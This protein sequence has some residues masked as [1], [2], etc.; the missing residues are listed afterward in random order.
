MVKEIQPRVHELL[1][2]ML[3]AQQR[4]ECIDRDGDEECLTTK[5]D[6]RSGVDASPFSLCKPTHFRPQINI[7]TPFMYLQ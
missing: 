5:V 1:F 7:V 4:F 3:V 6:G 2:C